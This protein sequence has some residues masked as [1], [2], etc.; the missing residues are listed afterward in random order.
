MTYTEKRM[1]SSAFISSCRD[2]K[3]CAVTLIF[4]FPT[5]L[6]IIRRMLVFVLSCFITTS[7]AF[8]YSSFSLLLISLP[9]L[10]WMVP[11]TTYT[12]DAV[13]QKRQYAIRYTLFSLLCYSNLA[14][15][16]PDRKINK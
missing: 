15:S 5:F 6:N 13:E 8:Y 4:L 11:D 2:T 10:C 7:R 1:S 3:V 14:I 12:A 9:N 16:Y